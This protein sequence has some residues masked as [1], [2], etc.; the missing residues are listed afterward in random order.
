M[1]WHAFHI[2]SAYR[3]R[4]QISKTNH[5]IRSA[6]TV[7]VRSSLVTE[8]E[9]QKATTAP[10]IISYTGTYQPREDNY[11]RCGIVS[12][13][14]SQPWRHQRGGGGN[15]AFR[16]IYGVVVAAVV[17]QDHFL[18]CAVL[19]ERCLIRDGAGPSISIVGV[20]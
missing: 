12:L 18:G 3:S 16:R 6:E 11:D 7:G 2:K 8:L 5:R 15:L 10:L 20:P 4:T 1:A 13:S 9:K 19:V 14:T 17:V